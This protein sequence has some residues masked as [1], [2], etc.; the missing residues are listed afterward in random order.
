MSLLGF[1]NHKALLIDLTSV[2]ESFL[3]IMAA[4]RDGNDHV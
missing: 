1:P 2:N 4:L 3:A